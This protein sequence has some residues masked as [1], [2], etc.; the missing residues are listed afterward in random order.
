MFNKLKTVT[1]E[2]GAFMAGMW[3]WRSACTTD[4]QTWGELS[5]YETGRDFVR[6]LAGKR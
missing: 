3:E 1:L 4:L 5:A 2:F 6:W